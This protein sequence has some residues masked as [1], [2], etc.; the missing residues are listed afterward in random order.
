MLGTVIEGEK[1]NYP[2]WNYTGNEKKLKGF[3]KDVF[4]FH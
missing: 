4:G 1:K 2:E 3:L